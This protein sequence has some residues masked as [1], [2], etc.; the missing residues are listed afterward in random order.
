MNAIPFPSASLAKALSSTSVREIT[1]P[2]TGACISKF[3]FLA[4]TNL[5]FRLFL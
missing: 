1:F 5:M 4:G 2:S 3:L